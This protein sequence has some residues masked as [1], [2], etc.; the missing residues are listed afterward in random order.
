MESGPGGPSTR[1]GPHP[2]SRTLPRPS[3]PS[4]QSSRVSFPTFLGP[5]SLPCPHP[6][7]P[8]WSRPTSTFPGQVPRCGPSPRTPMTAPQGRGR[9]TPTDLAERS[10]TPTVHPASDLR[11]RLDDEGRVPETHPDRVS[12]CQGSPWIVELPVPRL[13][14]PWVVAP[15][16]TGVRSLLPA[17][18]SGRPL[19]TPLRSRSPVLSLEVPDPVVLLRFPPS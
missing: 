15:S 18:D 17:L 6:W 9:R 16:I 19:H 14:D 13:R 1:R 2:T 3:V 8:T 5:T 11:L 10:P 4:H 7:L 12:G